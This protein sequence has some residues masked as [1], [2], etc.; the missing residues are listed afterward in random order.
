MNM[1]LLG[2]FF[3]GCSPDGAPGADGGSDTGGG[4]LAEAV[5]LRGVFPTPPADGIA[6]RPPDMVV[7]AFSEKQFCWFTRYTGED[8]GIHYQATYQSDNGHHV[9][10]MKTLASEAEFPDDTVLDCTDRN[11]LP[12][13]QMEPVIFGR[14]IDDGDGSSSL[15]LPDGMAV[16]FDADTRL[17]IQSHYVNPTPDDI[18]VADEIHLGFT[19]PDEVDTWAAP[20][21]HTSLGF[22]VPVGEQASVSFDCTWEADATVLFLGGHM[23]EWGAAFSLDWNSAAGSERIYEIPEWDPEYRDRPPINEYAEGEFNVTQG[24]SF[25]TSCTWDNNTNAVLG[26]PEE[27]CVTF[28]FAY[29]SKVPLICAPQ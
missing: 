6:L 19:A 2:L 4:E 28:G 14:G 11:T 9:V 20:F 1:L 18:L 7:P 22:E 26:F 5:D 27:M 10:L 25:T 16:D 12:M 17:V 8:V 13:T 29:E 23:H 3:F 24:D 21:A 15:T